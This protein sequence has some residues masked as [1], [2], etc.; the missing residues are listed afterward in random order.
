M[1]EDYNDQ[2][3]ILYCMLIVQSIY[4]QFNYFQYL[5]ASGSAINEIVYWLVL[6]LYWVLGFGGIGGYWGELGIG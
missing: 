1:Y 2:K 3:E 6:I 5:H 4:L